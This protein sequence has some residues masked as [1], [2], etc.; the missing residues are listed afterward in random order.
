MLPDIRQ[1]PLSA[2]PDEEGEKERRRFGISVEDQIG[3]KSSEAF[4]KWRRA[5]ERTGVLVFQQKFPLSDCRGFT[6]FDTPNSPC[7]VVNKLEH[8]DV[9]K[10]FTLWH[11][12]AHLML[13]RPGVC[14]EDAR[15]PIEAF[16]NQFAA[17]FLMPR[18]ALRQ[19]LP[20][21]PNEP[22]E[23]TDQVVKRAAQ[24]LKVS[25][26]ALALRLEEVGVA[27]SGFNARFSWPAKKRR[28]S[29]G[30]G[31][32]VAT[33][34]SEIGAGYVRRVFEALEHG[35]IDSVE[36]VQALALTEEHFDTARKYASV[37]LGKDNV[38]LV[39]MREDIV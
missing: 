29:S 35:A 10:S 23:W 36:A 7:I 4:R 25:Q 33:R 34:L 32:Y 6:L 27:P 1:I 12:Y 38:P 2:D 19:V 8:I 5:I 39:G 28:V 3:W 24:R 18:E 14:D 16:C 37:E 17:A 22:I 21:W 20:V 26:R 30:G 11:E 13:R 31:N 15:S 9:A